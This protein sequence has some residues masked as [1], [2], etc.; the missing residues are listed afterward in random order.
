[1]YVAESFYKGGFT[2]E[3]EMGRLIRLLLF[4]Q[5]C[6]IETKI[7]EPG[8]KAIHAHS[9]Y[10]NESKSPVEIMDA[11]WF[12]TTISTGNFTVGEEDGGFWRW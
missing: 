7:I 6:E 4:M 11:T 1:M 2:I 3:G 12:T 10:M 8:R 9:K 5:Y